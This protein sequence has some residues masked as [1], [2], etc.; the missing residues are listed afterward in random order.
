M[1]LKKLLPPP[2]RR[3][4]ILIDPPYETL[5]DYENIITALKEGLKRFQTGVYLLWYP[6]LNKKESA[7]LPKRLLK[8][9]QQNYLNIQFKTKEKNDGFGLF[10]SGVFIINPPFQL[11]ETTQEI[12][13]IFSNYCAM[14]FEI[15]AHIL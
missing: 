9:S 10:G 15:N 13:P 8:L 5:S 3:G 1:P 2:L 4:I 12:L 14:D 6:I 11:F 7:Q